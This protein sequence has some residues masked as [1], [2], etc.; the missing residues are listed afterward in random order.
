MQDSAQRKEDFRK[1]FKWNYETVYEEIW[2][3]EAFYH[4][5]EIQ[6]DLENY[7]QEFVKDLFGSIMPVS[8]EKIS[9]SIKKSDLVYV[10]DFHPLRVAKN[11]FISL[12]EDNEDSRE[13]IIMLE[14]FSSKQ[15]KKIDSYLRGENDESKLKKS[16]SNNG[17]G[18]YSW[19]GLSL[20]LEYAQERKIPI[21]G[22][23]INRDL[24]E[25]DKFWARKHQEVLEGNPEARIFTLAGE[26]HLA[27][28]HLPHEV[29]KICSG[30]KSTTI[31]QGLTEVF[32]EML[33]QG[34][35]A[36]SEAV[37]INKDTFCLNN[38]SPLL[39]AL[40]YERNVDL[41]EFSGTEID[42]IYK[43]M[44]S[45]VIKE[46]LG[47]NGNGQDLR[48]VNIIDLEYIAH[49]NLEEEEASQVYE[50]L[51]SIN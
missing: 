31:Y 33:E 16:I 51:F 11:G 18:K 12:M 8:L 7:Y 1:I 46:S 28:K 10:S 6:P 41:D 23:D 3:P 48:L 34:I 4:G 17:T 32:W 22:I 47:L 19:Q 37:E 50:Q 49:S 25:R 42:R 43:S 24:L 5:E 20:I 13:T 21:Y 14:A 15:Q 27:K 35:D 9:E 38:C 44:L 29:E 39:K 2:G 26:L 30:V 45:E 40:V 36:H